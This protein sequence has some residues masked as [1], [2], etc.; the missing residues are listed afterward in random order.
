M[1]TDSPLPQE[2]LKKYLLYAKRN[3]HPKLRDIDTAKITSFY[4]ALRREAASVGGLPIGVRHI[5]SILRM[6]E[7]HA[8]IHLREEVQPIDVDVAIE[9]MLRSFLMSQ[10]YAVAKSLEKNFSKYLTK[11]SDPNQ[12]LMHLLEKMT[13]DKMKYLDVVSANPEISQVTIPKSQ[14]EQDAKTY[15]INELSAFYKSSV[16]TN[17]YTIEGTVIKPK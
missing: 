16:F 10:K 6:S 8:R 14:L 4:T 17:K 15:Q 5:E 3:L 7:A 13:I 12:L 11:L 1:T 2:L 9:T